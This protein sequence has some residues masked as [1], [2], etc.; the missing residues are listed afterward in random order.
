MY[1]KA[2]MKYAIALLAVTCLAATAQTLVWSNEFNSGSV[3]DG[4]VWSYDLGHGNNG[5]GN[6]ELQN[7]TSNA[8]NVKV[9]SGNLVITAVKQGSSFTSAR[10][11]TEDKLTFKYGTI[12]A[13]IQIPDLGNGLWPAFWTLGNNHSSVGWP[14]CGEIDVM[15]MGSS[16]AIADG[17]V[18]RRVGS[19]AHWGPDWENH[20]SYGLTKD[21]TPD[22]DGTFVT[23]RMEWTPTSIATY[24]NDEWIWTMDI[25]GISEFHEPHF[26]ILNLAVGGQYTGIYSASGITAPFPSEYKVDWIRIYDNGHTVLGG[27]STVVPPDPGTNLLENPGFESGTGDWSLN[28]SGGSASASTGHARSGGNSM[29]I[30]STGAGDWASPNVS[31]SFPASPGDVFNLQG[32]MLNSAGSPITDGSFGLFKIEFRNA[33]GTP[34]EPASV[35]VGTSAGGPYYGAESTPK[36]NSSSATDTWILSEAQAEAPAGAVEVGFYL[37][38]VNPPGNTGPPMYFD[39]VYAMRVGDPVL[40]FTLGAS[41]VGGNFEIRFPTQNGVSYDVEYKSS[42]TNATWLAVET[43]VGDGGTNSVTYPASSPARF[44]RVSTP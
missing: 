24:I 43:I 16:G 6:S 7:Y 13:R 12:E 20:Y 17:A 30:D 29:V 8:A 39:D 18:N 41:V 28:L 23:Y 14:A 4:D 26:L 19:T 5:W 33:S 44:Y 15:E 34:L 36:L 40:P 3:L 2:T 11:K 35:D 32:Y 37:L 25:S 9:E 38:N 27:S 42:L 22:I 21:M 31:Q 1:H 10:V